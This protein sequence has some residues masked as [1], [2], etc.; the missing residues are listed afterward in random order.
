M[1]PMI[2]TLLYGEVELATVFDL[3]IYSFYTIGSC[4]GFWNAKIIFSSQIIT[5]KRGQRF[6]N[7]S[8]T[9]GRVLCVG[10]TCFNLFNYS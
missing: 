6:K 4:P 3:N 10:F 7:S 5:Y 9:R 8:C 1:L 2:G